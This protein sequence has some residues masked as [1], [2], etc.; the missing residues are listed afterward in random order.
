MNQNYFI[1]PI[2]T[3]LGVLDDIAVTQSAVVTELYNAN[4]EMTGREVFTRA[5]RVGREHVGALVNTLVLAYT[6]ASMPLLLFFSNVEADFASTINLEVFA[7]EIV[8]IIVGSMGLILTVPLVTFLAVKYLKGYT[9]NHT[10]HCA[11]GHM[12]RH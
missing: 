7:T 10:H 3:P 2:I 11:H 9:S 8:R 12:H 6:G 4:P 1:F 5:M